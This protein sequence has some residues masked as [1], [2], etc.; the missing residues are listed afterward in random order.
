VDPHHVDYLDV[1]QDA[2]PDYGF[3]LMR[4]QMRR[5]TLMRIRNQI[6]ASKMAQTLEKV[7]K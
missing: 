5:F 4:I 6:L 2:D 1:D 7:L 3:Y